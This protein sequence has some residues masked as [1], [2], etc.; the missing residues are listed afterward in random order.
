MQ[1]KE[2]MKKY[3]KLIWNTC[4][5]PFGEIDVVD[6]VLWLRKYVAIF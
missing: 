1:I 2:D 6:A 5:A 4:F 3:I